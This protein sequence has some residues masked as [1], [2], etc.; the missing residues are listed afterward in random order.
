MH[1]W[2]VLHEVRWNAGPKSRQ[3]LLSG[4]HSTTLSGYVFATKAHTDNRKTNLLH[5]NISSCP[6]NM[7]SFGSL[8]AEICWQVW[9]TAANFNG[10][11]V[12][13]SLLHGTLVVG[14]SQ[15]LRRWTEGYTYVKQGGHN[16]WP[17]FLVLFF[18]CIVVCIHF[19]TLITL[20][21]ITVESN[22]SVSHSI[23][24]FPKIAHFYFFVVLLFDCKTKT[25]E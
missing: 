23:Y 7:V 4:H 20:Q 22:F 21:D 1:I 14:V 5:S 25:I 18:L 17:A 24:L 15:T 11:R 2:N 19:W 6:Y 13:A 12:L 9:G 10:F 16:H 8:A 3:K